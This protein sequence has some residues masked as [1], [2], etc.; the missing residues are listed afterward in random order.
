MTKLFTLV[1]FTFITLSL[2][3]QSKG[4]K[5]ISENQL[6]YHLDFL[7]AKEFRGRET[8]SSELS[9]AS[10]YIAN[11]AKHNGLKPV[12]KNGSYYQEIPLNVTSVSTSGTKLSVVRD[13]M[14]SVWRFGK[15]FGGSFTTNG[16]YSG[17]VLFAGSEFHALDDVDLRGKIVLIMD[18][19]RFSLEGTEPNPWLNT[20]LEPTLSF[21]RGKGASA[22]LSIVSPEK[23]ERIAIP[24]GFYD[25]IP[26]GRLSIYYESQRASAN[27]SPSQTTS[28]RPPMPFTVAEINHKLASV[29]MGV[30]E[31]EVTTL[32]VEQR[33][34]KRH[35]PVEYQN[36]SARL[37]VVVD[38]YKA[39]APN[40]LAVIEGSDPVLKSEFVVVSSHHD[41]R[42]IDDGEI[43]PGADDNLTGVIAMM[44]IGRALLVERPKRSVLF[45]WF[46]GEEQLMHGSNYFVNN[47]PV[48][49]EKITA[50]I[51]LDMLG[52]NHTD[53]LYLIGSDMLSSELD[54]AIHRVN[55]TPGIKFG[56][57]YRYSNTTHPMRFYVRSDH[58][59]FIR[60]GIPAVWF[61]CGL[62]N[63]YHT[64]REGVEF[65]DFQ[66][67]FKATKL[68]Y[69]TIME[70]G[71][72]KELLKLD[73]HPAVTSRGAHNLSET[74]LY[75]VVR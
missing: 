42:G 44:E 65:V 34:G 63:D 33:N 66:K 51:N 23:Q 38:V 60:F 29:L 2:F 6:R 59:P 22:V 47:C 68:A 58:Y 56:F 24:S 28:Q 17:S 37:D 53:S 16:S 21:F 46:C 12:M 69:L 61:F 73:L 5:T 9:I 13:G 3:A 67:F 15:S 62:T 36:V 55:N 10:R 71:N 32:F 70:V 14:E 19:D 45:A 26:T 57:D 4:V 52:R 72:R 31:D 74:S 43:I 40:V 18:D 39:T 41:G 30:S 35:K 49:V 48:P 7:G 20:R 11:W 25:Y 50:C 8:P 64:Y 1:S 27:T 54:K 75:Q